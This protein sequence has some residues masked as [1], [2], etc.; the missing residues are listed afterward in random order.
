MI[1]LSLRKMSRPMRPVSC[2]IAFCC[3]GVSVA[4]PAAAPPCAAAAAAAARPPP[5]PP[6][7]PP[8]PGPP[9]PPKLPNPPPPAG[10]RGVVSQGR[11]FSSFFQ[12]AP[13]SVVL[14]IPLPGPLPLNPHAVRRR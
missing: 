8:A 7:P 5:P 4:V 9:P 14:Y 12:V 11:P 6:P 1:L 3:S 10:G 2:A 13:P